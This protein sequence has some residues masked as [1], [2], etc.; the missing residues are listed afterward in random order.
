M[1]A[2]GSIVAGLLAFMSAASMA[3]VEAASGCVEVCQA[4]NRR[5]VKLCNYPR[6]EIEEVTRCLATA[7]SN[8]D[9]CKQA[10]GK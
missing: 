2:F 9:A 1:K 8:F 4:E 7:R 10:C 3:P 6:K 5:D